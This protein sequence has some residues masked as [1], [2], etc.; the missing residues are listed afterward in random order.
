MSFTD[1]NEEMPS[2]VTLTTSQTP[3]SDIPAE[4]MTGPVPVAGIPAAEENGFR[5]L[6]LIAPLMKAI[7]DSGYTTPTPIQAQTIT[8]L[9]EGRDVLGQAQTGSGKTG[10]FALPMLPRICPGMQ[11]WPAK[12]IAGHFC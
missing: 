7:E 12:K 9:L 3:E 10:A 2:D 11:K 6:K 8:H 1:L 4:P 5:K